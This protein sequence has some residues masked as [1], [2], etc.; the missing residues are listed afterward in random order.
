MKKIVTVITLML[1]FSFSAAAQEKKQTEEKKIDKTEK[2][3]LS[4][5][6]AAKNDAAA[7]TEFLGLTNNQEEDFSRLFKMKHKL[8][9]DQFATAESKKE[10]SRIVG[11]KINASITSEQQAKLNANPEL[12]KKLTE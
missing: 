7:I 2:V 12:L 6:E 5:T 4:P 3:V 8:M 10:M 1:A 9:Q 11:L